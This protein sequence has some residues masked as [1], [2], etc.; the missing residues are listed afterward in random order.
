MILISRRNLVV[1][2]LVTLAT[3]LGLGFLGYHFF[4]HPELFSRL[5]TKLSAERFLFI[6]IVVASFLALLYGFALVKSRNV[7]RELDKMISL[8]GSDDYNPDISLRKLGGFGRQLSRLYSRL[9][10]LNNKRALKIASQSQLIAFLVNS[11]RHPI[12]VCNIL[13][14][15]LYV[16][17]GY[18]ENREVSRPDLVDD[19]VDNLFSGLQSR[20]VLSRLNESHA[21]VDITLE[22]EKL[23]ITVYPVFNKTGTV[24]YLVYDFG[25]AGF[26]NRESLVGDS[27]KREKMVQNKAGGESLF[28][29]LSGLFRRKRG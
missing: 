29:S 2:F 1:I 20:T 28:S 23:A 5:G 15:V 12:L 22:K 21:P 8:S 19:S 3:V 10:E 24:S 16:S 14:K 26:F 17:R 9:G 7:R 6:S 25:Q 18:L 27:S 13:G 11:M 4:L